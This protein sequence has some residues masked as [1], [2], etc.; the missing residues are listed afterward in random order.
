MPERAF[1]RPSVYKMQPR[2][3]ELLMNGAVEDSYGK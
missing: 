1:L 2:V 3:V